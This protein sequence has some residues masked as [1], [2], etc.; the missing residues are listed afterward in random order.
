MSGNVPSLVTKEMFLS[1][2]RSVES[3]ISGAES[4]SWAVWN[5]N[6]KKQQ[7]VDESHHLAVL[8]ISDIFRLK[9]LIF[10]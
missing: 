1:S 3:E 6:A 9:N 2:G 5:L 7:I 10:C 8:G 4:S